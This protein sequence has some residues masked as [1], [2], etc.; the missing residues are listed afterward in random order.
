M[1]I[2]LEK[3]PVGIKYL[4]EKEMPKDFNT[5][6][7]P[8]VRSYCDAVRLLRGDEYNNGIIVTLDSIKACKWCPV[9]LVSMVF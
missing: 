2:N 5:I 1:E 4:K 6:K 3:I 8:N 9:G 7:N